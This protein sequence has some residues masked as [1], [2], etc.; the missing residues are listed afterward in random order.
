MSSSLR[1][2]LS[3][4]IRGIA[5]QPVPRTNRFIYGSQPLARSAD[6]TFQS[7]LILLCRRLDTFGNIPYGH[8]INPH[9]N[10]TWLSYSDSLKELLSFVAQYPP[11]SSSVS[12]GA[13]TT[14]ELENCSD[15]QEKPL[16]LDH[17]VDTGF[18]DP[19]VEIGSHWG[20]SHPLENALLN[21]K[22]PEEANGSFV[23][24]LGKILEYQQDKIIDT[25]QAIMETTDVK[26]MKDLG[27][28]FLNDHLRERILLQLICNNHIALSQTG[29]G[30][31][32]ED[33]DVLKVLRRVVEFV[34][35]MSLMKYGETVK[36]N[37]KTVISK[38]DSYQSDVDTLKFAY[39][40]SHIYYVLQEIIKNSTRAVI[41]SGK[42]SE[43]V[44][45]LLTLLYQNDVPVLQIKI[46]DKGHGIPDGIV[47]HLFDYSFTTV[48]N[49][50]DVDTGVNA[51]II[52]GMGYGLPL[53]L[54][55]TRIFGGDLRLHTIDKVG[56]DV[57]ACFNGF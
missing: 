24:T 30:V 51:N 31:V 37:V 44:D 50:G 41:E 7:V 34:N 18:V 42:M 29:K 21:Y 38:P 56:T 49:N 16:D 48:N 45:V 43:P 46:S 12:N 36:F 15:N 27:K 28:R 10:T 1:L 40:E 35:D 8:M 4:L 5:R 47:P 57:Y 19:R 54:I 32:D 55:Y 22:I 3:A 52:A 6:H 25:N 2:E 14:S 20:D 23:S 11:N 53:S 9:W 33:L 26:D 17:G 39:I 13:T